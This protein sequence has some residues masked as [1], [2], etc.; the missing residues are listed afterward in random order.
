[1]FLIV[2]AIGYYTLAPIKVVKSVPCSNEFYEAQ[3]NLDVTLCES[4]IETGSLKDPYYN[5]SCREWCIQEVAYTKRD[6][7]L[8][9]W[10]NNFKD[11]PHAEGWDDPRETGSYRDNCYTHLAEKLGDVSLCEKVETDWAKTNCP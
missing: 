5:N 6:S 2:L 11:I 4:A 3:N 7:E 10:I 8:C 9:A 1:M